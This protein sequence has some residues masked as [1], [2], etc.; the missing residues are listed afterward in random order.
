[1]VL[2]DFGARTSDGVAKRDAFARKIMA[3]A[4]QAA[5]CE[6]PA[7][8]LQGSGHSSGHRDDRHYQQAP[9]PLGGGG[10]ASAGG[11]G[12]AAP[13]RDASAAAARQ[14]HKN[15]TEWTAK[16]Q[17]RE[18]SNFEYLM[19]LN[20][21][22][23][24]S[25]NDLCQYPVFPWVLNDYRTKAEALHDARTA[26][27][28]SAAAAESGVNKESEAAVEPKVAT[29]AAAAANGTAAKTTETLPGRTDAPLHNAAS[30]SSSSSTS[31]SS[32]SIST[33]PMDADAAYAVEWSR[34]RAER[35]AP[36][37]LSDPLGSGGGDDSASSCRLDLS[38]PTL[39]RDLS[40]P[41]GAL[42]PTRY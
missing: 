13:D 2:F 9:S 3:C 28:E 25:F 42:D 22:A 17:R 19:A 35:G 1:V 36:L 16:W 39:F 26:A 18:V 4:P 31:S 40:K 12:G 7:P 23:G 33:S 5:T 8:P 24:R 10:G 14:W 21:F 29:A 6:W 15:V 30:E 38:D 27:V 20:T 34:R 37:L 32:S 41:M 11:G